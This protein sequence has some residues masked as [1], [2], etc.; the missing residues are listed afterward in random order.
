MSLKHFSLPLSLTLFVLTSC[1]EALCQSAQEKQAARESV[2]R[3]EAEARRNEHARQRLENIRRQ[4]RPPVR[5][6]WVIKEKYKLTSRDKKLL[7]PT[8]EDRSTYADFLR[9]PETG[10][11]RLLPYQV[12]DA[13][14][15]L[16]ADVEKSRVL[17]SGVGSLYSFSKRRYGA[18]KWSE[19]LF[20]DG[21]LNV[22][23]TDESI[24]LLTALGDVPIELITPSSPG[25]AE[26]SGF[27]PATDHTL[28]VKLHLQSKAALEIGGFPYR[29]SSPALINTTYALRSISHSRSDVIIVF[30]VL[31]EA[32]NGGITVLW[33]RMN[34]YPIR[35]SR[36][37]P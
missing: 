11:F 33:K 26:L 12:G 14:T 21:L 2:L 34:N 32:S 28:A 1:G 24:G 36:N 19:I 22:G 27:V 7:A 18:D 16:A 23:I 3:E 17:T 30:R 9:Q 15:V 29:S 10:L 8:P 20:R 6:T 31:H 37:K 25:V 13:R 4:A 35:S 5:R